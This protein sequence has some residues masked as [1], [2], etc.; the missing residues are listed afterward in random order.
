[1]DIETGN[2]TPADAPGWV[3]RQHAVGDKTPW[4]YANT[5][6]MPQ[7]IDAL[8]KDSIKRSEYRVFTAHYTNVPHIEA[9]SDA[10]QFE[11]HQ[12]LYDR[13]LCEPYLL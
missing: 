10:T 12:E 11:D 4:V 8:T 3:R 2:A 5:S 9:G 6:T 13:S 7:V 1:L